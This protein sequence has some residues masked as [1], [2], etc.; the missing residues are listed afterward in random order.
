[1]TIFRQDERRLAFPKLGDKTF[2]G[3]AE[4]ANG[5]I[6]TNIKSNEKTRLNYKPSM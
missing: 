4:N 5:L 1:M 3:V 6:I 2:F